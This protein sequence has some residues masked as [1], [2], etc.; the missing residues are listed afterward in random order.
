MAV[1]DPLALN[2]D[3]MYRRSAQTAW[4]VYRPIPFG[5]DSFGDISL[6]RRYAHQFVPSGDVFTFNFT[7][8]SAFVRHAATPANNFDGDV[9]DLMTFSMASPAPSPSGLRIEAGQGVSMALSKISYTDSEVTMCVAGRCSI[10]TGQRYAMDIR[11][12]AASGNGQRNLFVSD[13]SPVF[14]AATGGVI[15]PSGTIAVGARFAIT[16]AMA[17]NDAAAAYN[18]GTV[19]T[20]TSVTPQSGAA[21]LRLGNVDGV[22]FDGYIE[23]GMVAPAR[24]SNSALQEM[25]GVVAMAMYA[26]GG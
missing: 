5:G 24:L 6:A 23:C 13:G 20:D 10:V 19:S 9:R 22:L 26:P 15:V 3:G 16:G 8:M 11:A 4:G 25:A 18:G 2:A 7:D 14:V 1:Y 21:L 12:S 17:A